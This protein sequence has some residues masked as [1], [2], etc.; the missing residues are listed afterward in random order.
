LEGSSEKREGRMRGIEGEEVEVNDIEKEGLGR[1][2]GE[3]IDLIKPLI[4]IG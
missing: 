2:I 4:L 3:R 1:K